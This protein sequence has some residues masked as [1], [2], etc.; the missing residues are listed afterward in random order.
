MSLM[1]LCQDCS[2][3]FGKRPDKKGEL[4]VAEIHKEDVSSILGIQVVS[5]EYPVIQSNRC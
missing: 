3:L 1:P 4:G 2:L 5:P